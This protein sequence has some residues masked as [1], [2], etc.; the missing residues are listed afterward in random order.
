MNQFMGDCTKKVR[1]PAPG[2]AK[3]KHIFR[4]VKKSSFNEQVNV[5]FDFLRKPGTIKTCHCLFQWQSGF[6]KISLDPAL[7]PRLHLA[8]KYFQHILLEAQTVA[9]G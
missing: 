5:G 8:F 6:A 3:G 2:I 4:P 9:S 7:A 1:F